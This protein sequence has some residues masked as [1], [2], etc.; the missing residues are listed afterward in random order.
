MSFSYV[1]ITAMRYNI[2]EQA[3]HTFDTREAR[4]LYMMEI[5]DDP[6]TII[7]RAFEREIK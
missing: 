6:M 2:R 1:L 3:T 5:D 7:L 4:D